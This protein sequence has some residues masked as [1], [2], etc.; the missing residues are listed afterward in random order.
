M[1]SHS[2]CIPTKI[3]AKTCMHTTTAI[4][5]SKHFFAIYLRFQAKYK[6][7]LLMSSN[8]FPHPSANPS[9]R[10]TKGPSNPLI[11]PSILP[12]IIYR[13]CIQTLST[14]VLQ[15]RYKYPLWELK[16]LDY[17]QNKSS[18]MSSRWMQ[19]ARNRSLRGCF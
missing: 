6:P 17:Q 7:F 13:H 12:R 14:S 9:S 4:G 18:R 15:C 8:T 3:T 19:N 10:F 11:L 1:A 16:S 5:K 2:L